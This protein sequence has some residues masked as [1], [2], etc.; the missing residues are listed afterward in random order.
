[1]LPDISIYN[2]K[3]SIAVLRISNYGIDGN[4]IDRIYSGE[5]NRVENVTNSNLFIIFPNPSQ[6]IVIIR[7]TS[8]DFSAEKTWVT[9]TM[10]NIV[11]SSENPGDYKQ[12][13]QFVLPLRNLGAGIY[14]VCVLAKGEL[15]T[16]KLVIY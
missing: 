2:F 13:E 3:G 9:G 5:P 7:L 16:L 1:M 14:F 4:T 11:W 12:K 15:K 6:D 8:D 10:G